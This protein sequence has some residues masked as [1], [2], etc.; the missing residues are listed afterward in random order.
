MKVKNISI[1]KNRSKD[2][3]LNSDG[4]KQTLN[5]EELLVINANVCF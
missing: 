2:V 1:R 3:Q 4:F 5:T